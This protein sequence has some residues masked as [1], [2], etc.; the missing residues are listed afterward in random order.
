M[1][2]A[3]AAAR[4]R[5]EAAGIVILVARLALGGVMLFYAIAKIA[6]PVAFLK[7]VHNYGILPEGW[8]IL[9]NFTAIVLP[10]AELVLGLALVLG[11]LRSGAGAIITSLMIAFIIALT[12]RALGIY[13]A[14]GIPFCSVHFD[15]GCGTGEVYICK[16]LAMNAL[17]LVM[18]LIVTFG[19]SRRYSVG[20]WFDGAAKAP[21]PPA[22]A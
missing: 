1:S 5:F 14:D 6:D 17:L 13:R 16:K 11:L 15:C 21:A 20:A 18:G 22:K 12:S 4:P 7:E 19:R 8:P 3:P 2:D 10:Y 9:T